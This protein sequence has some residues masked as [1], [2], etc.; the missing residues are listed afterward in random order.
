M[1]AR[2][3]A[4]TLPDWEHLLSAAAR[5]QALLP[6]AVLV[7]GTAAGS[8]PATGLPTTPIVS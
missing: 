2:T 3:A 8:M 4:G 6:G 7:R 5:L 1:S